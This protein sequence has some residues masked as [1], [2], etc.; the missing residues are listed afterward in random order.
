[1]VQ[2]MESIAVNTDGGGS[3]L[4]SAVQE[5]DDLEVI[6]LLSNGTDAN[7]RDGDGWTPLHY[8]IDYLNHSLHLDRI[9]TLLVD[10]GADVNAKDVTGATPLH[11]TARCGNLPAAILLLERGAEIDLVDET[12]GTALNWAVYHGHIEIVQ[13]LIDHGADI[14][15]ADV[16]GWRPLHI[17][18]HYNH[19]SILELLLDYNA[20]MKAITND[21]ETVWDC[22]GDNTAIKEILTKRE[23]AVGSFKRVSLVA[24][25]AG[26]DDNNDDEDG[27]C[28]ASSECYES[29]DDSDFS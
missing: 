24:V 19:I 4:Q 28:E 9:I 6:R 5:A 22:A 16:D 18:A 1:M 27:N 15:S 17:A 14:E 13:V 2:S 12:T 23:E 26:D 25:A 3:A 8:A 20:D 11:Y 29:D 10:H 21:N 7:F